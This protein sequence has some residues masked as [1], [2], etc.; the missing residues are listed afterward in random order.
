[1]RELEAARAKGLA[2]IDQQPRRGL[3]GLICF[4]HP[5]ASNGVLIEYAQPQ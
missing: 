1:V 2:L 4:L 5:K 3:A